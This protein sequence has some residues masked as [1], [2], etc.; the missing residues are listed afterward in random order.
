MSNPQESIQHLTGRLMRIIN[1]HCRIEELPIRM[2]KNSGLTAKEVHCI[3]AIGNSEGINIKSIGDTLG[4]TKSAASQ[5]VGK[6]EKKGFARK[7]KAADNDKEILAFLTEPGW[8]AYKAHQEFHER[9]LNTLK[10]RLRDFP[11]TQLA[12]A[13]AILAVVETVVDERMSEL[14]GE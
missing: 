3:Q 1:K 8:E 10:A 12:L 4:V 11:D 13:S 2:G 7:E 9:H 14:F 5:M 6:L